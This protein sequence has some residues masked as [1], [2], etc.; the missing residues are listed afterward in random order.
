[1][2][3]YFILLLCGTCL[4]AIVPAT[5]ASLGSSSYAFVIIAVCK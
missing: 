3:D 1:M 5:D 2:Q 4:G